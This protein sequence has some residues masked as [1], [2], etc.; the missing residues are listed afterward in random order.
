[1]S[2]EL[3]VVIVVVCLV[4]FVGLY[5]SAAR[6]LTRCHEEER[7]QMRERFRLTQP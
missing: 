4:G 6:F 7:R 2:D 1:M 5:V 3:A